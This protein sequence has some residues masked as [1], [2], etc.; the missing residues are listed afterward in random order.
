MGPGGRLAYALLHGLQS[1]HACTA[2]HVSRGLQQGRASV[3]IGT[4]A[5][6]T[7][8]D[9]IAECCACS[10]KV[11][12]V[13]VDS[14]DSE[15]CHLVVNLA[16]HVRHCACSCKQHGYLDDSLGATQ[17]QEVLAGAVVPQWGDLPACAEAAT[18]KSAL[19]RLA[20]PAAPPC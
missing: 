10:A 19:N 8:D 1:F 2:Q 15:G 9:S 7:V 17:R 3:R 13:L 12:Q 18:T 16:H 4:T 5:V 11:R 14:Q 6:V 20:V